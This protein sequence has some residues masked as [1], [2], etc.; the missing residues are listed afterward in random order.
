MH[1]EAELLRWIHD[2]IHGREC[3]VIIN[4]DVGMLAAKTCRPSRLTDVTQSVRAIQY[5]HT[6]KVQRFIGC[7]A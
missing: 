3:P 7:P 2:V 6:K 4:N 1:V 5:V